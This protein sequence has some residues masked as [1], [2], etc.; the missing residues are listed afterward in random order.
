[1]TE[2]LYGEESTREAAGLVFNMA[3]GEYVTPEIEALR[4]AILQETA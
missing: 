1:M 4:R 2:P 3:T